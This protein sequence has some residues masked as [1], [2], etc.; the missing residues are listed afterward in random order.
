VATG[1]FDGRL[2]VPVF[3]IN[4]LGDAISPPASQQF[5]AEQVKAAGKEA[6][7]RQSY[8]AS[9]G[10]CG[11]TPAETVVAVHTLMQRIT[12]GDWP[13]TSAAELQRASAATGLGPSRFVDYVPPRFV[14]PYSACQMVRAL[15]AAHVAPLH[16]ERQALPVCGKGGE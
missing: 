10:H 16:A 8:T 7:L 4:G 12:S 14:R 6:L 11:F 5:Y 9:A 2:R 3:T 1:V 13:A 15:D